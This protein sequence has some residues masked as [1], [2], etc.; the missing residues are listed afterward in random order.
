MAETVSM[1]LADLVRKAEEHGDVGH[2]SR[3]TPLTGL[4][5]SCTES[6]RVLHRSGCGS[7]SRKASKI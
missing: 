3:F 7:A 2:T 4:I 1:A 5:P 6:D